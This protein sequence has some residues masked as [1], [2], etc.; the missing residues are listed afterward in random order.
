MAYFPIPVQVPDFVA[1]SQGFVSGKAAISYLILGR[2]SLGW[3]STTVYGDVANYLDTS[4][5]LLNPVVL[6]TEYFLR[7]PSV[8]DDVAGREPGR[9]GS[10][11]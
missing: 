6:G 5:D 11:I 9:C 10:P 1:A 7:S 3:N 2:R 8:N 4:Q